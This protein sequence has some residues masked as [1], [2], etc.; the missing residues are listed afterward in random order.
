MKTYNIEDSFGLRSVK[1]TDLGAILIAQLEGT[2]YGIR[3]KDFNRDKL[4]NLDF[5]NYQALSPRA[6]TSYFMWGR[7]NTKR[8]DLIKTYLNKFYYRIIHDRFNKDG[9]YY[10]LE[11][12]PVRRNFP[13]IFLAAEWDIFLVERRLRKKSGIVRL[14]NHGDRLTFFFAPEPAE[15][16]QVHSRIISNPISGLQEYLIESY[17]IK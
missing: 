1:V 12:Q 16:M 13:I 7:Y 10:D 9:F 4:F 2:V 11:G 8:A 17:K 14:E 3:K 5:P 15:F 6:Y